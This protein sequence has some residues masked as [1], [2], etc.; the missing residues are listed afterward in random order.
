MRDPVIF[1]A[2][3]HYVIGTYFARQLPI[4]IT[5]GMDKLIKLWSVP[6]WRLIKTISGHLN[7]V[8]SLALSADERILASGSTDA[9]IRW[10]SFPGG[11]PLQV[12][13]DR[14]KTVSQ[15]QFSPTG[16][17][18]GGCYYGGYVAIWDQQGEPV[19]R[20]RVG[21]KNLSSLAFHP[22]EKYFAV[23]GLGGEISLWSIPAGELIHQ[24][25]AHSI[26][27][28]ELNF[29]QSGRVLVSMGYDQTVKFWDTESWTLNQQLAFTGKTL[30]SLAFSA[31]AELLAIGMEGAI[32]L[33]SSSPWKLVDEFPS[34]V[35]ALYQMT[36]SADRKWFAC[37]AADQKVRVWSLDL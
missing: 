33:W 17:L 21:K 37:G 12:L 16:R 10:W 30:R 29:I 4:L 14:K 9:S 8:N 18:M 7:S 19:L 1:Q 27:A 15:V 28:G 34:G 20:L 25:S 24:F 3:D 6:D 5:S 36:F 2:H 22:G 23:S 35:K 26:A 11:E 31:E 32:Q 13:L